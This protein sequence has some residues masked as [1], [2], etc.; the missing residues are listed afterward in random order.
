M[1]PVRHTHTNRPAGAL[2]LSLLLLLLAACTAAVAPDSPAATAAQPTPAETATPAGDSTP[3]SASGGTAPDTPA[4]NAESTEVTVRPTRE[5]QPQTAD[6]LPPG[7]RSLTA[8]WNTN[9]NK[10]LVA[11]DELLS[12]GP[13]RDGI[14]SIDDPRFESVASAGTWLAANEPVIVLEIAGDARAY[15][16]QILTWHEIANDVVGGQP[17]VVTFCPLCN[18]ALAFDRVVGGEAFEFGVSGLLRHSDLVMYDRTTETLWQQFTGEAIIG[19]LTGEQLSFL[20]TAIVSFGDFGAAHP[21]GQV[22]S[23]ETGL[24]DPSSYGTNP[25]AGYD[26]YDHILSAGGNLALFS[27]EP[28]GRLAPADRVVTVSLPEGGIDIAYPYAVLQTARVI[29][30][31]Q[32]GRE[33]VV[34]F[35]PGTAS[36]LGARVIADAEDVGA[37]GV[38]NPFVDGRKL[39]FR[40]E[41]DQFVD[42][43]TG[44]TW[45]ILGQATGGPLAGMALEPIVHGDHFWFS[46]AAFRPETIIFS[47]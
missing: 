45:N 38:F 39:T 3:D 15:P 26:T 36:A 20:P 27:D 12:G 1:Q 24:R 41:G 42:A 7:V 37:T 32:G 33:L 2:L 25:Y 6:D 47:G 21:E 29:N 40:W 31:V 30:D 8:A 13:P 9:W 11:Y 16:L 44:S 28:D 23:R 17:V 43:E 10:S 14:Q 19:D 22:L 4:I 18:S 46:W 34:F 5:F 35:A